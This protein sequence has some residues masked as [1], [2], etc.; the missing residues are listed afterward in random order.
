MTPAAPRPTGRLHRISVDELNE[1]I[2][3]R[4]Y[5][6]YMGRGQPPAEAM[7]HWLAAEKEIL[8]KFSIWGPEE[9]GETRS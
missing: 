3:R 9:A 8:A 7:E 5:E 1:R 6:L 4:A 2:R